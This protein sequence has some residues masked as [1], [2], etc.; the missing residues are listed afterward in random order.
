M[1]WGAPHQLSKPYEYESYHSQNKLI[2]D[3]SD[4]HMNM[5]K[6][7]DDH[8][9]KKRIFLSAMANA[10]IRNNNM[11]DQEKYLTAQYQSDRNMYRSPVNYIIQGLIQGITHIV[12][13]KNVQK[14]IEKKKKK[15]K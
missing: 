6:E 4:L 12:P 14:A 10:A 3:Y 1:L 13:G 5:V 8:T 9:A 15:K 7:S 2:F 11:P